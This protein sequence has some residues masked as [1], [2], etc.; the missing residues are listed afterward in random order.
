MLADQ[1]F[2]QN[3][4]KHGTF[5]GK[6]ATRFPFNSYC[7]SCYLRSIAPADEENYEDTQ[8]NENFSDKNTE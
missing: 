8:E 5:V 2:F 7:Y 1:P 4:L 6:S 3:S